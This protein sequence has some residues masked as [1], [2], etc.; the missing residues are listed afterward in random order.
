MSSDDVLS[1]LD[2]DDKARADL[3]DKL[4]LLFSPGAVLKEGDDAQAITLE[5]LEQTQPI[6]EGNLHVRIHAKWR[7]LKHERATIKRGFIRRLRHWNQI[8]AYRAGS[9]N[10]KDF[11]VDSSQRAR[12]KAMMPKEKDTSVSG[13][14][15]S[16]PS[17]SIAA[18]PSDHFTVVNAGSASPNPNIS[19]NGTSG[20]LAT[21]TVA[22]PTVDHEQHVTDQVLVYGIFPLDSEGRVTENDPAAVISEYEMQLLNAGQPVVL[23]LNPFVDSGDANVSPT[24]P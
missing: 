1:T 13:P 20:D 9:L 3:L 16:S 23:P 6:M 12:S 10:L 8:V 17:T 5:L 7:T 18:A 14:H 2:N 4:T 24:T 22:S 21:P 15:Q 11:T 19:G